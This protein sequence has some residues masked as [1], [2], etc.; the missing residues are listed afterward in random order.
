MHDKYLFS[1]LKL[2]SSNTQN[3]LILIEFLSHACLR[4]PESQK[5]SICTFFF[6]A[7]IL[8]S[9]SWADPIGSEASMELVVGVTMDVSPETASSLIWEVNEW[10]EFS[11]T[12]F[13]CFL[14]SST[15]VDSKL[16]SFACKK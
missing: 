9:K 10:T 3:Q 7:R 6:R 8:L 5:H 16:V 1:L 15:T 4:Y 11:A 14:L 12:T 2:T 13:S